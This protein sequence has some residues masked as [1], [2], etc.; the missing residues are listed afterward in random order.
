MSYFYTR[1]FEAGGETESL[2]DLLSDN[3]IGTAQSA[4]LLANWLIV[5]GDHVQELTSAAGC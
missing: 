2:I 1:F 3:Y 5:T 4:N